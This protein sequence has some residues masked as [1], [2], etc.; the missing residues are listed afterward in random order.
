LSRRPDE[1]AAEKVK[2][3]F[4]YLSLHVPGGA[5][6]Q[7]LQLLEILNYSTGTKVV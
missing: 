3:T 5:K 7:T 6:L 4:D 2:L 1:S